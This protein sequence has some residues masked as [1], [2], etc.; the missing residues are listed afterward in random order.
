MNDA[1][2]SSSMTPSVAPARPVAALVAT[3]AALSALPAAASENWIGAGLTVRPNYDGGEQTVVAP[4]PL[5]GLRFGP[6]FARVD[7]G[8]PEAGLRYQL[9]RGLSVGAQIAYEA[10]RD[11][12]AGDFPR[13]RG[14]A[15]FGAS[16]SYGLFLQ[17]DYLAFGALP[18]S[19][20]L[21]YRQAA[22]SGRGSNLDLNLL[23]PV[24]GQGAWRVALGANVTWSS[25]DQL[26]QYFGVNAAQAVASGLPLYA[27]KAGVRAASVRA[28]G[29]YSLTPNWF[30]TGSLELRT[31]MGE[32]ADSPLVQRRESLIGVFG[33]GY[34]F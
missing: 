15:N 10:G 6:A 32:A 3:A 30:L 8:I 29:E 13:N 19:W 33:L 1:I 23:V 20:V 7:R 26:R 11:V 22:E 12:D 5:F 16:A 34:R 17:S 27:P 25:T 28:L 14:I 2:R 21:R 18:F 24:Y 31:L 9:T 4:V